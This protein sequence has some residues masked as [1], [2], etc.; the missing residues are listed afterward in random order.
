[1]YSDRALFSYA[2]ACRMLRAFTA[3]VLVCAAAGAPGAWAQT[4][5][6]SAP[7]AP[8]TAQQLEA[9]KAFDDA[10]KAAVDGP[11]DVPLGTQG[12]LKLPA[13]HLFVPQPQAAAMLRAMGNPGRDPSLLGLVFPQPGAAGG[14]WL[15]TLRFEDAGFVKDDDAREWNA[16]ELLK[17]FREGTEASNAERVQLG[18]VPVEI[19][20]WAE[21]PAYDAATH[22]LVWA[23][24]SRD[25]N[26]PAAEPQDVNYNTYVL[27]REG[28]FKL[29]LVTSLPD[30]PAHKPAAATMLAAL[31]FNDGKRYADFNSSTDRVAE[32]GLAALVVG[33]AAKKLGLIAVVGLFLAKF[34]KV[35]L[36]GV[37]VFGAGAVKLLKRRKPPLAPTLATPAHADQPA[38]AAA[39]HPSADT[40]KPPGAV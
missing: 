18:G 1:M 6:A 2:L 10:R 17:S 12:L 24:A 30:L 29:N 4:P 22:R 34:A 35:I 11:A 38:P 5:A 36:L 25:K 32:Y 37:A 23:M 28:Y 20:G 14:G 7:A 21:K 33:V 39:S 16:D 8:G 3:S 19:V 9:Q 27:G 31:A 13:G 15:M 40:P 26:A